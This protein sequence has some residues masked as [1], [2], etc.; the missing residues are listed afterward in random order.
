[1]KLLYIIVVLLLFVSC[2][3]RQDPDYFVI[4]SGNSKLD[5]LVINMTRVDTFPSGAQTIVYYTKN[6]TIGFFV[7]KDNI[8]A[9]ETTWGIEDHTLTSFPARNTEIIPDGMHK[10]RKGLRP[11]LQLVKKDS[12]MPGSEKMEI[13]CYRQESQEEG[14]YFYCWSP[15]AGIFCR[16]AAAKPEFAVLQS[17]DTLRNRKI[18]NLL[19]RINPM[20]NEKLKAF[21][22]AQH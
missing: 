15:A 21:I 2:S 14:D 13:F 6:D 10:E 9:S 5:T 7:R 11:Q 12:T 20:E 17:N 3:E 22:A 1:M 16:Y 4:S 19:Q 8:A 18:G